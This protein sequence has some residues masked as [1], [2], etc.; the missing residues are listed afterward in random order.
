MGGPEEDDEDDVL[1]SQE[2]SGYVGGF[3]A[4]CFL[5]TVQWVYISS[6][7]FRGVQGHHLCPP[8]DQCGMR[9]YWPRLGFDFP[10]ERMRPA[11]Y[12]FSG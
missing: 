12:F 11:I 8:T 2:L 9:S 6:L 3:C 1:E 4:I 10:L 7:Y 5:C